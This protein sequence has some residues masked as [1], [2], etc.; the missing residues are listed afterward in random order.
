M[1]A[2][3]IVGVAVESKLPATYAIGAC[4]RRAT[5]IVRAVSEVSTPE[6]TEYG[7]AGVLA[8]FR[9]TMIGLGPLSDRPDREHLSL[10]D[11]GAELLARSLRQ[12]A[13]PVQRS[14]RISSKRART[15]SR[16]HDGT[17]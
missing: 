12:S 9:H 8:R 16:P 4:V 5:A 3:S 11:V 1:R 7:V 15:S 2:A 14:S 6:M 10:S 17:G 13:A